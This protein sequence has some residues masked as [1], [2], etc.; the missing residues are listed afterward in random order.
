MLEVEALQ[1]AAGEVG[2]FAR[3]R[4]AAFVGGIFRE[5]GGNDVNFSAGFEGYVI[6]VGMKRHGHRGGQ[7]PGSGCPDDGVD[8][9][10]SERGIDG[11][12]IVKQSVLDP[13]RRASVVLVFDF[14]FGERGFIVHAPVDGAQAFVD[15]S[16]F[17]KRKERLEHHR[18]I[19][20]RHR[21]VGLVEASEDADALELLALQ[22]EEFLRILATLGADVGWPHLQ[23]FTAEFL[24]DLDFDGQTVAIPARDVGRVKSGHGFRLDDE[25]LK[26]LIHRRAQV[27]GPTRVRRS[28]VQDVF[29]LPLTGLANAFVEAHLLPALEHFG[30][31][32]RET[33]LHGEAGLG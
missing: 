5:L 27:D 26:A 18:L 4:E 14:G 20:R 3:I 13:H 22:V 32:Q 9:L 19:L 8:F 23:L 25:I 28:I 29:F 24:V 16:V 12:G 11:R 31:V 7:R 6:L 2:E 17:V 33:R 10:A 21:G 30:F 15:E 1:F